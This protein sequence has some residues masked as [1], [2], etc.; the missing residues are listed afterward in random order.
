M[1][2]IMYINI[3]S[4]NGWL[5]FEFFILFFFLLFRYH[6]PFEAVSVYYFHFVREIFFRGAGS[7][8]FSNLYNIGHRALTGIDMFKS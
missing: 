4:H 5:H 3:A 7:I 6:S 8:L 1:Y 2:N